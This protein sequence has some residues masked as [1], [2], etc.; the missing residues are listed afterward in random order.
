MRNSNRGGT[1]NWMPC[2]SHGTCGGVG[3]EKVMFTS[4]FEI[5]KIVV[6]KRKNMV[7]CVKLSS[8]TS[9]K[10]YSVVARLVGVF[11]IGPNSVGCEAR[12]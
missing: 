9:C 12:W 3:I 5:E 4:K 8:F 6:W 1:N 10:E 11:S 7:R 2:E